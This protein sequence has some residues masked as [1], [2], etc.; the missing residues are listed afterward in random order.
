[1]GLSL[2]CTEELSASGDTATEVGSHVLRGY[3]SGMR[4][5]AVL[6]LGLTQLGQALMITEGM[7]T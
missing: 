2:H 7:V 5:E 6:V 1:M 3:S 4:T